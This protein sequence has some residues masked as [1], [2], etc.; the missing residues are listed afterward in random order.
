MTDYRDLEALPTEPAELL[1][2]STSIAIVGFSDDPEK[3]SHTAAMELVHRG[4]QV[5]PVNPF[6]THINGIECY[7]TLADVPVQVDLVDVFR[8]STEAPDVA[9]AAVAAGARALW[10]QLGITS[11]E[12]R[13]IAE[14]AGLVYVEDTCAGALARRNDLHAPGRAGG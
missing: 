3:P 11:A 12:A 1:A 7:P 5:Y 2:A 6:R 4:W 9:R 14:E 10:L 8:P 13:T